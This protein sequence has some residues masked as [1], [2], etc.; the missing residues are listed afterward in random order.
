MITS[1]TNRSF[2]EAEQYSKFILENMKDGLLPENFFRNVSDFG[3]GETLHIKSIGEATIQF[4]EEDKPVTYTP[5]ESGEITMKIDQYIGDAWYVTDVM[6]QDGSQ[7]EVLTAMR[8]KEATRALQEYFESKALSTLYAGALSAFGSGG[9]NPINGFQHFGSASGT[10]GTVELKDFIR[11]KLAFD[12]AEV[13]MAGRIAIVDPVVAASLDSKFQSAYSVDRNP[14]MME[15]LKGGFDRDHQFV[16]N[17]MGWNIM[18][19]NRLPKATITTAWKQLDGSTNGTAGAA[20]A[21]LFLNIADDQT[22]SLMAAWRQQPKVEGDRNKDLARDE[23][24]TRARF[25]FGVQR[26]DTLGVLMASES[27]I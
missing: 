27:A 7:I 5:I 1:A 14:E 13:P 16:M 20:V 23:Y 6:R 19:S 10:G 25:G 21:S 15:L 9:A 3:S 26:V 24:V 18:T 8:A 22:K 11:M 12:K 17:I 2:I 4:V